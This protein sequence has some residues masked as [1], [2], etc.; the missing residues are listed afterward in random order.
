MIKK[1]KRLSLGIDYVFTGLIHF[2]Y[3]ITGLRQI[4]VRKSWITW[5]SEEMKSVEN[6]WFG[7]EGKP[8]E[9]TVLLKTS[10]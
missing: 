10:W 7:C 8:F 1:P 4:W 5:L 2:Q 9:Q 6:K 3:Y